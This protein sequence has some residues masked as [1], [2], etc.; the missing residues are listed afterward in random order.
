MEPIRVFFGSLLG[1]WLDATRSYELEFRPGLMP[2][3]VAAEDTLL[4]HLLADTGNKNKHLRSREWY[5]PAT[6]VKVR[7]RIPAGR[8]VGSVQLLRSKR[9]PAAI[10]RDGWLEIAIPSVLIHEAVL[11]SLT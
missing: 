11:V 4:L 3:F 9:A 2:H 1:P 8:S 5:L 10:T 7:I 6:D